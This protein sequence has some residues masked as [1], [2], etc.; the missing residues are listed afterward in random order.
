MEQ[1]GSVAREYAIQ[2]IDYGY[3]IGLGQQV[4]E[5]AS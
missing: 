4:S 5:T 2:F 3:G 1:D